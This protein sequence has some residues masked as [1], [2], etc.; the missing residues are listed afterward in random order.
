VNANVG[1]IVDLSE[2]IKDYHDDLKF[3]HR[4]CNYHNYV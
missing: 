1:E 4:V 2:A 3:P